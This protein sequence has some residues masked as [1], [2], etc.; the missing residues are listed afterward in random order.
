[1]KKNLEAFAVRDLPANAVAIYLR[2][3]E[4]VATNV[5]FE[6]IDEGRFYDPV[7]RLEMRAAQELID[8]L[9]NCGLRPTQGRQSEGATEAQGRHLADMRAIAFAKLEITKP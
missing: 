3:G 5:T 4:A 8:Q 9:W 6:K 2:E 1:M 7:F